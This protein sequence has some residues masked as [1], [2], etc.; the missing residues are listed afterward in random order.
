M[1]H[2]LSLVAVGHATSP[3]LVT[4]FILGVSF[5]LLFPEYA[6]SCFCD[7]CTTADD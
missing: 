4:T 2:G 3:F 7:E 6:M 5:D 1:K